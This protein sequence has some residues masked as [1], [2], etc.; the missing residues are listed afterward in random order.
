MREKKSLYNLRYYA[1]RHGYVF[2]RSNR[3]V[4]APEVGRRTRIE[5]RL[6]SYGYGL[7]LNL[8]SVNPPQHPSI[9]YQKPTYS[10]KRGG[11]KKYL[12]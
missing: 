8:F 5:D 10:E 4:T 12:K 11:G 9:K 1:R 7:Q 2:D 6:K 3:L